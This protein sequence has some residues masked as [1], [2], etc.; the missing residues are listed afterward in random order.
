MIRADL[1]AHLGDERLVFYNLYHAYP[2]VTSMLQ[3]RQRG[4][5]FA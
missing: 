4:Y 3:L 5:A 1:L 2:M